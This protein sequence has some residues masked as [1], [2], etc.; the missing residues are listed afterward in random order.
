MYPITGIDYIPE[1]LDYQIAESSY[2]TDKVIALFEDAIR[3]GYHPEEVEQDIYRQARVN[4][5]DFTEFDKKR[6]SLKVNEIYE[7][8]RTRR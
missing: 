8:Y 3:K 1:G 7:M 5:A 2:A 4:P 6:I